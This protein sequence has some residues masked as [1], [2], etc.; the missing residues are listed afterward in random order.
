[1]SQVP[2][3][4]NFVEHMTGVMGLTKNHLIVAQQQQKRVMLTSTKE[5]YHLRWTNKC[6]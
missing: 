2:A 3:A 1:M 4:H 5:R 6:L